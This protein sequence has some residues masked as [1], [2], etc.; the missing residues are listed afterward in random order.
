MT[1]EIYDDYRPYTD[2]EVPAAIERIA[3]NVL[4]SEIVKYASPSKCVNDF[5]AEFKQIRT[6]V[7]FQEKVMSL[8]IDSIVNKTIDNLTYSG[9]ENMSNDHPCMQISN[10]RDIVLDS[11]I[12][13][14]ILYRNGL[15]TSEITFGSNL[16]RP[17][18]VVDIGKLNKM[19]KI[20]RGGSRR[21]FFVNSLNVSEYM[22]CAITNKHQST[23]IA[24][25]NG[26]TKDG[27]DRTE[28]AVLKMFAMSSKLPFVENLA[29]LNITPLAVSYEIEPCD[30]MKTREIYLT[31]KHGKYEKQSGEDLLS[32]LH[33]IKQYKGNMNLTVC[34][35]V[36]REELLECDA[37]PHKDKF[38][39]L[40]LII[41]KKIY[42]GYKLFKTNYLAHDLRGG[43]TEFSDKYTT[44]DKQKFMD[45]M[46]DGLNKLV[47]TFQE[48]SLEELQEIFLG[49]YANPVDVA[50]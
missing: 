40:A 31:R 26:R 8:A 2:E 4:F 15:N 14:L 29:E 30:F 25:R 44:E 24:Q 16:M 3:N 39:H 28:V 10:H 20:V 21:E 18:I 42:E 36:S 49:I 11:A 17:Q 1:Q 23:W 33:G 19:F 13:E 38:K 35:P 27:N 45:Y 43:K 7:E 32:I 6:V 22:R 5:I 47:K 9:L 34:K 48:A 12:L 41:D 37:L 46:N 50:K